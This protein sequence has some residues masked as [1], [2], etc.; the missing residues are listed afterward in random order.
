[1]P[2]LPE[3]ETYKR[4]LATL[5]VNKPIVDVEIVREKSINVTPSQFEANVK[6]SKVIKIERRAKNL[7]FTLENGTHLLLH[8]MLGGSMFYGI[9]H[10]RPN[11]SYQVRIAFGL[12]SLYLIGLRLGYLHLLTEA[13]LHRELSKYG[14]EPLGENFS[15]N[16]FKSQLMRKRGRLKLSLVDQKFIAGIGNCHANEI[17]FDACILPYREINTL[18]EAEVQSLYESMRRVLTAASKGGGYM[19]MPL[20]E[21][22][23]VT[24]GFDEK[25]LVYDRE[26]E[27]C[28]RCGSRI[29]KNV[30]SSRKVFYCPDC[31]K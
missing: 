5:V 3:M 31:Q 11:R 13:E 6:G 8:L 30:I 17:C 28:R 12:E 7:I 21:G 25:C 9:E 23:K 4:L 26:G 10:V 20:Y 27:Q 15:A 14:P 18:N 16:H 24:G 2:E 22:D 29:E 1:M 19:D